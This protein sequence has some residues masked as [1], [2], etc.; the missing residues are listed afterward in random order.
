MPTKHNGHRAPHLSEVLKRL[1]LLSAAE[2]LQVQQRIVALGCLTVQAVAAPKDFDWLL[3]GITSELRQRG[4]W[5]QKVIPARIVPSRYKEEAPLIRSYLLEGWSPTP[6]APRA[7]ELTI[8]GTLAANA[9]AERLRRAQVPVSVK[10]LLNNVDKV[11][12]AL[13]DA[14]PGYWSNKLLRFCVRPHA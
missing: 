14:F 3:A 7:N 1:P 8:L 11:P 12:A 10:T 9:L 6:N 2:L 13:D 4:L 5:A